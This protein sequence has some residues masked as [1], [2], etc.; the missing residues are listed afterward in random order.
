MVAETDL[1]NSLS[2]DSTITDIVSDRIYSDIR[3][4]TDSL[5]AIFFERIGTEFINTIASYDP[6]AEKAQISL[7]CFQTTRELADALV[8]AVITTTAA[9]NFLCVDKQNG[10]D[11]TTETYTTT[12]QLNYLE[13]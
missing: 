5:P 9:S 10:F 1:Y 7:T 11:E 12:I 4:Q 3:D 6:V 13:V 2:G 8:R